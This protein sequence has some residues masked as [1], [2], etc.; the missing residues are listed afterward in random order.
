MDEVIPRGRIWWQSN[1][2]PVSL[3]T[4]LVIPGFYWCKI[5][6]FSSSEQA[7][8][9]RKTW[10]SQEGWWKKKLKMYMS[11]IFETTCFIWKEVALL[12]KSFNNQ[13]H[14]KLSG[15]I[16]CQ[17]IRTRYHQNLIKFWRDNLWERIQKINC[18]DFKC[19]VLSEDWLTSFNIENCPQCSAEH[20]VLLF[21]RIF[22][23]LGNSK[24]TN[25]LELLLQPLFL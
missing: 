23:K 13:Y 15:Y 5:P 20:K 1:L 17:E 9:L 25:D 16:L 3:C 4:L 12:Q 7:L 18:K 6:W 10:N 2:R 24:K 19:N 11:N 22:L 21:C 14:C 8:R